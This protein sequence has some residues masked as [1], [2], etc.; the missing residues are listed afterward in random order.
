MDAKSSFTPEV[1]KERIG[2]S[3]SS[4]FPSSGVFQCSLTGLVFN[5]THEGEVTYKI[6]IWDKMDL[7]PACKFPGGP[8]YSIKS[9]QD[10]ISQLHL[11]HCEPEPALVSQSL[12]VVHLTDDG[13]SILQPLEVTETHVVV[14]TPQLTVF[15][16]VWDII[17]RFKNFMT[18]PVCG[19]ILL[20][21]RPVNRRGRHILSVILLPS[22]VPLQEVKDQHEN[23]YIQAPAHCLLH[24]GLDYSLHSDP[25]GFKIQPATSDFCD[26]YG[27]NYHATFEIV[28][29]ESTEEVTLM[30]RD[31]EKKQVW[32]HRLHLSAS[33][34]S[35]DDDQPR[36][37]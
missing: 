36:T 10:C 24:M 23:E 5:V 4:K 28:L 29:V 13:M 22:N 17:K 6:L 30:V 15:G 2:I 19:Q 37:E 16:I 20:F 34:D 9:P 35:R 31:P 8:L 25:G 33:H 18:K 11:P 12:S 3:Y 14:N 27:P 32:E 21:L 7:E 1:T 26:N